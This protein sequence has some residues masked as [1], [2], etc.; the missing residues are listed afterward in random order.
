M[1]IITEE[2]LKV[3]SIDRLVNYLLN[4]KIHFVYMADN[5]TTDN[6]RLEV[7]N[8]SYNIYKTKGKDELYLSTLSESYASDIFYFLVTKNERNKK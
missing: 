7:G 1:T 8:G 3:K 4:D 6:Y 5:L 2:K